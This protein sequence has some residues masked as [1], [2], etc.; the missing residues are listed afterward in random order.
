MVIT[1]S[2]VSPGGKGSF[3]PQEKLWGLVPSLGGHRRVVSVLFETYDTGPT[4]ERLDEDR[5]Q[6]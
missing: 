5:T 2:V 3:V 4:L 6:G 1:T